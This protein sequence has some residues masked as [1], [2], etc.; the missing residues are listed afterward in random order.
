MGAFQDTRSCNEW[1][2][3]RLD[4]A[5]MEEKLSAG[6]REEAMDLY[7]GEFLEGFHVRGCSGFQDG[8]S[9]GRRAP[10][11]DAAAGL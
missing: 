4:V 2:Q 5:E 11:D 10:P 3:I 7:Q 8:A 1:W 9:D 6:R